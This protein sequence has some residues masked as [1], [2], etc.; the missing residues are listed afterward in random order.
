MFTVGFS[1]S[2][3]GWVL[4]LTQVWGYS[5]LQAG[6]AIAIGPVIVAVSAPLFGRLAGRI[7]QRTLLV[8]GGLL[9]AAGPAW[10]LLRAT[11]TADYAGVF[12]PA[13]VLTAFGVSLCLPQ[14][15][16]AAVQGLPADQ[17]AAGSAVMQ[18][19]RY[20]GSTVGVALVV[21]LTVGTTFDGFQHVWWLAVGCGI[22]VSLLST[23]LVRSVAPAPAPAPDPTQ[24]PALAD[25]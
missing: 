6:L 25:A 24:V 4:F 22:A 14:L 1:G 3:L 21:A 17:F 9:W 5:I 15:S 23:R 16:S 8:P 20:L 18:A 11:P 12:A 10:L 7:G 19:V 2:F 13:M